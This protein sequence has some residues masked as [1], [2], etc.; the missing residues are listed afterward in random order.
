MSQEPAFIHSTWLLV[1]HTGRQ[2]SLHQSHTLGFHRAPCLYLAGRVYPE[3]M[4]LKW[5]GVD[6][7]QNWV[8]ANSFSAFNLPPSLAFVLVGSSEEGNEGK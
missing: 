6:A 3:G 8:Y 2:Q 4:M 5:K 1:P 7:F